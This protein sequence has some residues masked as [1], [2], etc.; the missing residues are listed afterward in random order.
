MIF[1]PPDNDQTFKS[2]K[3]IETSSN[4]ALPDPLFPEISEIETT[5]VSTRIETIKY[6][7]YNVKQRVEGIDMKKPRIKKPSTSG[8]IVAVVHVSGNGSPDHDGPMIMT[9]VGAG[10]SLFHIS[11][12]H[13]L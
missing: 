9:S 7:N 4:E 2:S 3:S 13:D 1:L 5:P 6:D 10:N 11:L 12:A 8:P